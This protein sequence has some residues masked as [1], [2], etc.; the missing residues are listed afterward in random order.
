MP[1]KGEKILTDDEIAAM[2]AED[3]P[4]SN[5]RTMSLDIG[6][7][8]EGATDLYSV[9]DPNAR[10]DQIALE[11]AKAEQARAAAD[12]MQNNKFEMPTWGWVAILIVIALIMFLIFRPSTGNKN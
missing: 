12:A 7:I 6:A 8:L 5:D 4:S 10:E 9:L 11:Q 2:F 3:T 1:D